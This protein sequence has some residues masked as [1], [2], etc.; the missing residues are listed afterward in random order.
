M[1]EIQK[2]LIALGYLPDPSNRTAVVAFQ[3]KHGLGADGVVGTKTTKAA[4]MNFQRAKG[5]NP[6]GIVGP[7]TLRALDISQAAVKP[8]PS[9]TIPSLSW[10]DIALSKIGLHEVG[11]NK[12]LADFLKSDGHALGDPAKLPWCGD[13]VETSL[14]LAIPGLKVPAN[15]Y[16]ALNWATWG[17]AVDPQYGAVLS[18]ERAGGGHVGF[19][20]GEN[21]TSYLVLGG[22]QSNTVSKAYVAKSQLRGSRMPPG[23]QSRGGIIRLEAAEGADTL[24]SS[25][26]Q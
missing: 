22:N 19:Y 13:F 25:Q 11:N 20:V 18:F 4:V 6:D 12:T 5:L 15:P 10:M 23:Y 21:S 9:V 1:N 3:K 14:R 7:K 2:K 26:M 8:V 24:D 16:W 17:E